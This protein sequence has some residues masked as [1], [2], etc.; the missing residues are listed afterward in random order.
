MY[1]PAT[2]LKRKREISERKRFNTQTQ[3]KNGLFFGYIILAWYLKEGTY[4]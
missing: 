1:L 3:L 4:L 2:K